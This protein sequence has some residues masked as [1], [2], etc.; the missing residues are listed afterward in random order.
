MDVKNTLPGL[1]AAVVDDA[2]GAGDPLLPGQAGN[3]RQDAAQ[4]F[5]VVVAPP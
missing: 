5:P 3:R 1:G 2:V 4:E